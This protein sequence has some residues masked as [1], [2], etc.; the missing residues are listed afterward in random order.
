MVL[1][2]APDGPTIPVKVPG[3]A[4]KDIFLSTSPLIIISG[5]AAIS[6]EA[7]D[8]SSAFGYEKETFSNFN[9]GLLVS[10][11]IAFFE[12][13]TIGCKSKTSNT[14]SKET[15]ALITSTLTLESAVNGPYN[16]ASNAVI[17]SKVP[18]VSSSLI[19]KCPPIPYATAVAT[20]AIEVKAIK[21]IRFNIAIDIP[22]SATRLA[23]KAKSSF[24]FLAS[25]YRETNNAPETLN[26][27]VMFADICAFISKDCLV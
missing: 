16:L 1:L 26:R 6:R 25:P 17:A 11:A 7:K 14:L 18:T 8:I 19:A 13:T 3:A 20:A 21:K 27:S 24:S 10:S 2:P 15:S 5:F 12:S 4:V 23:F 9:S 22:I